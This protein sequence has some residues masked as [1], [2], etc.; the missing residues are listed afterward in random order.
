MKM[1]DNHIK[2]NPDDEQHQSIDRM[3]GT[4]KSRS[5]VLDFFSDFMAGFG[6]LFIIGIVLFIVVPLLLFTLK[7]GVAFAIPIAAL[8]AVIILIAL[9]G[10]FIK[11]IV[12][13]WQ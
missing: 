3:T 13:R 4:L 2:I 8:G 7:I 6:A 1:S 10:R 5:P 11:F 9:F 12:K